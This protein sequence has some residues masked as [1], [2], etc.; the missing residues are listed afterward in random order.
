MKKAT[1]A[2]LAA[3]AVAFIGIV[4]GIAVGTR[5]VEVEPKGRRARVEWPDGEAPSQ[6]KCVW[7]TGL[8]SPEA[9]NQFRLPHDGGPQYV[10]TRLCFPAPDEDGGASIVGLPEGMLAIQES[11]T[12][13]PFD[14]GPQFLAV[15]AGEAEMPCACRVTAGCEWNVT[16]DAGWKAA[17]PNTT[18]A[19]GH[20]REATAGD[21]FRKACVELTRGASSWPPECPTE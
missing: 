18:L 10:Q 9:L 19:A 2:A 21:C 13:E 17:P 5:T 1:P 3:G 20:W 4:Y 16:P 14:G 6:G 11:Q 12:E 15:L 8:A 7:T